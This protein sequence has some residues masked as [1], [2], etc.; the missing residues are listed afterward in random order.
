MLLHQKSDPDFYEVAIDAAKSFTFGQ[1]Y[2]ALS[3]CR[4]LE[5]IHLLSRIPMDQMPFAQRATAIRGILNTQKEPNFFRFAFNYAGAGLRERMEKATSYAEEIQKGTIFNT[6]N[7]DTFFVDYI[8][9]MH[10]TDYAEQI[11]DVRFRCPPASNNT[12]HINVIEHNDEFRIDFL[13]CNDITP[14]I[15][16]VDEEL[17]KNGISYTRKPACSFNQPL[18]AWHETVMKRLG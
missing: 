5:G 13:S 14:V 8:G 9:S 12:L 16:A 2:V 1:V 11:E 18:S 4:T 3:R 10:K 17:K 6:S 15:D 7:T